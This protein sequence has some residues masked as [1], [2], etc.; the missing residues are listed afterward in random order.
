MLALET[1]DFDIDTFHVTHDLEDRQY[2]WYC[3]AEPEGTETCNH[4]FLASELLRRTAAGLQE[5]SIYNPEYA[6]SEAER[7]NDEEN[8]DSK[9]EYA[10]I[11]DERLRKA[12]QPEN[13]KVIKF[14]A[15]C[16]N[17]R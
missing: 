14:E 7:L 12:K 16:K 5:T 8:I 15:T 13:D 17:R 2:D 11:Y 4:Y 3:G 6:V 10:K 1:G 9:I